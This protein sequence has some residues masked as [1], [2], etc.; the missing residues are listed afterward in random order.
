MRRLI[1]FAGVAAVLPMG[2]LTAQSN[3]PKEEF[4]ATA[5]VNNEFATGAGIVQIRINRWTGEAERARLVSTLL[6]KGPRSLLDALADAPSVGTI[7][8]PDTL[9]YD[10]RYAHQQ[11][12]DDGGR[13]IVIATDRPIGFWEQRNNARTL[14]YPFTVVQMQLG[15]NGTGTGTLSIAT[16]IR[17]YDKTIELENFGTSPAMLTRIESRRVTE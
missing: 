16:K 1:G 11:P 14:D 17:A 6:Q 8:T 4:T 10:L 5:V 12:V 13:R 3:L 2:P 7:K 15:R 9:A